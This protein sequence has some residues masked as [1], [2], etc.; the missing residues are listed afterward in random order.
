M[1]RRV[2]WYM[3][4]HVMEKRIA[5]I[6]HPDLMESILTSYINVFLFLFLSSWYGQCSLSEITQTHLCPLFQGKSRRPFGL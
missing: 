2:V 3:F 4:T 6:V 1:W 5:F